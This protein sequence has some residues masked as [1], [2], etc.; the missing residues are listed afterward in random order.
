MQGKPSTDLNSGFCAKC[1]MSAENIKVFRLDPLSKLRLKRPKV[2]GLEKMI[3]LQM[4][5]RSD[6]CEGVGNQP[7]R[8]LFDI[9]RDAE[10]QEIHRQFNGYKVENAAYLA[11]IEGRNKKRNIST[12]CLCTFLIAGTILAQWSGKVDPDVAVAVA[13]VPIAMDTTGQ[14]PQAVDKDTDKKKV[15]VNA[16]AMPLPVDVVN[17]TPLNTAINEKT[18]ALKQKVI[19]TKKIDTAKVTDK[20]IKDG[21]PEAADD[22]VFVLENKIDSETLLRANSEQQTIGLAK[23]PAEGKVLTV[24]ESA[25]NQPKKDPVTL[26]IKNRSEKYGSSG[27]VALTKEGVVFF[28]KKRKNQRLIG[29]GAKLDDGSTVMGVD[30]TR[31]IVKTDRGEI[32]LN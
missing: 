11:A 19:E 18:V 27:I 9:E 7:P 28:D 16:V 8:S 2:D 22:A 10:I 12:C 32:S 29:I 14:S 5:G 30:V 21:K 20:S 13:A 25:M 23:E 1:K 4:V 31:G 15:I 3:T 26:E 6:R 24:K 17:N